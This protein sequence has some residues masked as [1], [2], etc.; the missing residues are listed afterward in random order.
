[1][2]PHA[3]AVQ[4]NDEP[5]QPLYRGSPGSKLSL[6]RCTAVHPCIADGLTVGW[7]AYWLGSERAAIACIMSRSCVVSTLRPAWETGDSMHY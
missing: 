4:T 6:H 3:Q 7:H 1:M 2:L 5:Q